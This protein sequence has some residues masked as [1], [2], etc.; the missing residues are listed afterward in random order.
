[1]ADMYRSG[2]PQLAGSA[3]SPRPLIVYFLSYFLLSFSLPTYISLPT[4]PHTRQWPAT[5]ASKGRPDGRPRGSGV[6][7]A[8]PVSPR[9]TRTW[10]VDGPVREVVT[11][12]DDALA[13]RR[14]YSRDR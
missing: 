7:A 13:H 3:T 10:I 12:A 4:T 9:Q 8:N 5:K 1:M 11:G 6:T 14:G 2:M